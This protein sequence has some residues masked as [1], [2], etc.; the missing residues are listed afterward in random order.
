MSEPVRFVLA[1]A[2]PARRATL[3]AAG[4]CPEVLVSDV[5]EDAYTA[6][7]PAELAHV[8]AVAKATF[9]AGLTLAD[10]AVVVGCDSVLDL[11]GEALG[12]PVDAEDAVRR[13]KSM[14]GRSATLVTGHC[15]ID[16]RTGR[17]TAATAATTVMF[18]DLSDAEIDA[19]VATGE[20]LNVAGA[21]TVDGLGGAFVTGI[22]GDHHNVVG[23]SLPLLRTMLADLDIAWTSLWAPRDGFEPSS[24][25]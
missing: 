21:F 23:I 16:T 17:Q 11:D 2:S 10:G 25:S 15:A 20:P 6:P 1:S 12:K 18:A 24:S 7:T 14:R 4:I 3:R 5:D 8:L 9:V 22:T 19:Y 13:W